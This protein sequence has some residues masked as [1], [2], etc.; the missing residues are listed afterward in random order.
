MKLGAPAIILSSSGFILIFITLLFVTHPERRETII[1]EFIHYQADSLWPFLVC[2]DLATAC[3]SL[4][5]ARPYLV[6][7]RPCLARACPSLDLRACS[8]EHPK[9]RKNRRDVLELYIVVHPLRDETESFLN[10]PYS[11]KQGEHKY[12]KCW[13]IS[14]Y[15]EHICLSNVFLFKRAKAL[16]KSLR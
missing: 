4:V 8:P 13:I 16:F 6:T 7:A 11:R 1:L 10:S 12:W 2:G 15:S 5:T 9:E 3:P 14:R